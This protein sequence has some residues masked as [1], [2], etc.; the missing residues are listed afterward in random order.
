MGHASKVHPILAAGPANSDF[1]VKRKGGVVFEVAQTVS[2]HGRT[3]HL[4][5]ADGVGTLLQCL[6]IDGT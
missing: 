3:F 2:T 4:A 6:A 1:F 5:R